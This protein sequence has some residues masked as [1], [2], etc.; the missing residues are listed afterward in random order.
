MNTAA[1]S[2]SLNTPLSPLRLNDYSDS[3]QIT[4]GLYTSSN[5]APRVGGRQGNSRTLSDSDSQDKRSRIGITRP[6]PQATLSQ[7]A[8]GS[9]TSGQD[10]LAAACQLT[11]RKTRTKQLDLQ[12]QS[13]AGSTV[14]QRGLCPD[15]AD[16][17]SLIGAMDNDLDR[18]ESLPEALQEQSPLS[19]QNKGTYFCYNQ[20]T[21]KASCNYLHVL[22]VC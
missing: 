8:K 4:K 19:L 17:A 2:S 14:P 11:N 15:D 10:S 9:S 7:L 13:L 20:K 5:G 3:T 6:P 1:C 21:L 18:P 22:T 16:Y 12:S